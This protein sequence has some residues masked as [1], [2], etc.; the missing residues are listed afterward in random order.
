MEQAAAP[1]GEALV[2]VGSDPPLAKKCFLRF[3]IT[4]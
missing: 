2:L 1:S 4:S 3:L